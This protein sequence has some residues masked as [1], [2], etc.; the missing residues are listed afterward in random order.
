MCK[1]CSAAAHATSVAP[2][3][4][5]PYRVSVAWPVLLILLVSGRQAHACDNDQLSPSNAGAEPLSQP[6]PPSGSGVSPVQIVYAPAVLP[7]RATAGLPSVHLSGVETAVPCRARCARAEW[8][9]PSDA[10]ERRRG[11]K[12]EVK[13]NSA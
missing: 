9:V 1:P 3:H 10:A 11:I 4:L 13:R 8:R 12:R 2:L 5:V 6:W 7:M